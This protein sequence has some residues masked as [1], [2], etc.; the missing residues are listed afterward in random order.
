MYFDWEDNAIIAGDVVNDHQLYRS[1]RSKGRDGRQRMRG[2]GGRDGRQRMR[3]GGGRGG[4]Q[5][6]RGG[7]EE[8]P[9]VR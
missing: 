5:R 7:G 6:M 4:R 8:G 3:G 2:G 9:G 1:V